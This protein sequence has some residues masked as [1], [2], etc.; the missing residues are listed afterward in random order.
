V[1]TNDDPGPW[2][3]G[4]AARA[5]KAADSEGLG[6]GP[7]GSAWE[8]P[9]DCGRVRRVTQQSR[10]LTV[11]ARVLQLR[12]SVK[13]LNLRLR[14]SESGPGGFERPEAR[15]GSGRC[16]VTRRDHATA[17]DRRQRRDTLKPGTVTV[18]SRQVSRVAAAAAA[19]AATRIRPVGL[20]RIQDAGRR[21][22]LNHHGGLR[23][24]RAR[25]RTV[26]GTR[27]VAVTPDLE[28]SKSGS[29]PRRRLVV[30][31]QRHWRDYQRRGVRNPD[32][33][34]PSGEVRRRARRV[35]CQWASE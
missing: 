17:R 16:R 23:R 33:P 35:A 5:G 34:R 25:T 3:I 4:T 12:M 20:S 6:Q 27:T 21:R 8:P 32:D 13:T 19:A 10:S 31:A 29:S 18:T 14:D 26:R 28:A 11:R 2:R 7:P 15:H 1:T 24:P 30:P 22:R 9:R